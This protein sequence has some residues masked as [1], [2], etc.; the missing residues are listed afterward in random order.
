MESL[1]CPQQINSFINSAITLV[2]IFLRECNVSPM[3]CAMFSMSNTKWGHTCIKG[4]TSILS[5]RDSP[6]CRFAQVFVLTKRTVREGGVCDKKRTCLKSCLWWASS[7]HSTNPCRPRHLPPR[8]CFIHFTMAS[9]FKAFVC[10]VHPPASITIPLLSF[11]VFLVYLFTFVLLHL[12]RLCD[13]LCIL[14]LSSICSC[15]LALGTATMS[16]IVINAVADLA[17]P[18]MKLIPN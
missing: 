18:I 13:I 16:T 2:R 9:H 5:M 10:P 15:V 1:Y 8:E 6:I 11:S 4:L 7:V 14:K 12:K 17:V 3:R